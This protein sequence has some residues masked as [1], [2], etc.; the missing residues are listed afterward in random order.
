MWNSPFAESFLIFPAQTIWTFSPFTFLISQ[1]IL[2]S[3]SPATFLIWF[4][5]IWI[6]RRAYCR[7]PHFISFHNFT[8][9]RKWFFRNFCIR[10]VSIFQFR[11][12]SPNGLNTVAA[13]VVI[14]STD[15]GFQTHPRRVLECVCVECIN[16]ICGK[17]IIIIIWFYVFVW[18][19]GSRCS[20]TTCSI[21]RSHIWIFRRQI[22]VWIPKV[23]NR[24]N[25]LRAVEFTARYMLPQSVHTFDFLLDSFS[26]T[27]RMCV[28]KCI[29]RS[30]HK[31]PEEK[32]TVS[33]LANDRTLL[34]IH[35]FA[36]TV[37][38]R[39]LSKF[40][41][42]SIGTRF[43]LSENRF[44]RVCICASTHSAP[45]QRDRQPHNVCG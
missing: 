20:T 36:C 15:K 33:T 40:L 14:V 38:W 27:S 37:R 8:F 30:F 7:E 34:H 39:N 31:R 44:S 23:H 9:H 12:V 24:N 13:V 2:R 32:K 1:K 29:R 41:N 5:S 16:R 26:F 28:A 45:Y 21:D 17:I 18:V 6:C 19:V 4:L 25:E 42:G 22:D 35:S 11:N 10:F 3:R 43:S